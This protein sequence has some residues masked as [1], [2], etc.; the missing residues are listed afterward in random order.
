MIKT[1][2]LISSATFYNKAVQ[3]KSNTKGTKNNTISKEALKTSE[4]KLSTKAK[5]YLT[6]LR[7]E[8][9]DYDFIIADKGDDRRALLDNSE[10]E[11]SVMFSIDEIERMAN[12]EAYASEKMR[13]VQT[14]VGM[15]D[16][17]CEQFG[18][19][20]AWDKNGENG[21]SINKLAVSINDDGSMSIFAELEKMSDK[22]KEHLDKMKEKHIDEEKAAEKL[23]KK[24]VNSY[25]KDDSHVKKVTVEASSEDELID[26]I[27]NIDWNKGSAVNVGA[28]FD[29]TV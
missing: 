10:K 23:D 5:E 18:F 15:S 24:N 27:T 20:R 3:Q 12:D 29:F 22:Y 13:N 25:K 2:G 17:I 28:R 16:R 14:I 8:Y 11:F 21:T 1:N 6:N 4:D 9:G 26:K 19:E 7:K